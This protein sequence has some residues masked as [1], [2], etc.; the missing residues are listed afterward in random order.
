MARESDKKSVRQ[1]ADSAAEAARKKSAEV[2]GKTATNTSSSA[3]SGIKAT[4]PDPVVIKGEATKI[5]SKVDSTR[6][7]VDKA[8][9]TGRQQVSSASTAKAADVKAGVKKTAASAATKTSNATSNAASAVKSSSASN[10]GK[11][12]ASSNTTRTTTS[13]AGSTGGG[14]Y[15]A[16]TGGGGGGSGGGS[17][18]GG[19]A[20]GLSALALGLGGWL[21]HKTGVN[22]EKQYGATS[23][24][25][26]KVET[27]SGEFDEV[28]QQV[29]GML[30]Q[31]TGLKEEV[32]T[33]KAGAND[34]VSAAKAEAVDQ[35]N[36]VKGQLSA[37]VTKIRGE[38]LAMLQKTQADRTEQVGQIRAEV[39]ELSGS[40]EQVYAEVDKSLGQWQ[41]QEVEQ[42]MVTAN[43]RLNLAAD[44]GIAQ[45][46]LKFADDRMRD[47]KDPAL[48]DV[49]GKVANDLS[50]LAAVEQV[51]VAGVAA[52]LRTLKNGIGNLTLN[53]AGFQ[54]PSAEES[55]ES[56]PAADDAATE[57]AAKDAA[58]DSE[59]SGAGG[60]FSSLVKRGQDT[61]KKKMEES[62]GA[63]KVFIPPLA[64]DQKYFLVENLRL[65][66][67]TAQLALF[68]RDQDTFSSS[69][70]TASEW[71]EKYFEQDSTGTDAVANTQKLAE[72]NVNPDLPDISGSLRELRN[73]IQSRTAQ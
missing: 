43:D 26:Q 48:A 15:N 14:S 44:V 46:A 7:G 2:I 23:G 5:D 67:S 66:Y 68:E 45:T 36:E 30:E 22:T 34:S 10:T 39:A 12:A 41:L 71:M 49:R 32:A 37:E 3:T 20:V 17:K 11:S 18:L 1:K 13:S 27:V 21:F 52:R 59:G 63:G 51:D 50:S 19:I 73:V 64:P 38:D 33:V 47:M 24:V 29:A 4:K 62:S 61:L 25:Q 60:L 42:L 31:V 16:N 69:L 9:K 56:E 58:Q 57:D 72:T 70:N 6:T 40:V 8:A 35:I 65:Q 54:Q 53:K 28:K 55:A